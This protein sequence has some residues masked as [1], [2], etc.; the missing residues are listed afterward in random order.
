MEDDEK[1]LEACENEIKSLEQKLSVYEPALQLVQ[2]F[3]SLRADKLSLEKSSKDSSR[4]LAR[5]SHKILLQEE[6][7]RK[8]V[9][10]H[11]PRVIKE[12]KN[13][14][15]N[16]QTTFGKPLVVNGQ[17][18][19][20][21]VIQ[22]EDEL[23]SKYPKSRLNLGGTNS[24]R[25]NTSTRSS[26]NNEG[27]VSKKPIPE[28]GRRSTVPARGTEASSTRATT[29]TLA[30]TQA[31]MPLAS[32]QTPSFMNQ[33][34]VTKIIG[35]L[36]RVN[37]ST[38]PKLDSSQNE[39]YMRGF[40]AASPTVQVDSLLPPKLV[41]RLPNTRIPE[42]S[43]I[44]RAHSGNLSSS[45]IFQPRPPTNLIRPTTLF[46]VSPNK[47]NQ[48]RSQIP[49]LSKSTSLLT[50]EFMN[51]LDKENLVD[52]TPRLQQ[53]TEFLNFSS[54]YREPDNSVYK[55]SKSPDG[56]C[57]LKVQEDSHLESGFDDTSIL[58]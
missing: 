2:E 25:T 28:K 52:S 32:T 15:E 49:T 27:R 21:I 55:I 13:G 44:T 58:D 24:R 17:N 34:P 42:P 29:Q 23:I 12:L 48:Q 3:E 5:N 8:R 37:E 56:K 18:M 26:S 30:A 45:P 14:L 41:T 4:L 39:K 57:T 31:P 33:T 40:K 16:I 38:T 54:P 20:E 10:R 1:L 36:P 19:I 35:G 22:V 47:I 51:S 6:K 53:K 11:L 43:H 7:T 50:Q 9:T 46:Q